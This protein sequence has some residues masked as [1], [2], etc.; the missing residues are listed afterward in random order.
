MSAIETINRPV[1][2]DGTEEQ[3]TANYATHSF[4]YYDD[5]AE[6]VDC[7]C[8]PWHTAASYPCGQEPDRETVVVNYN[9]PF[10]EEPWPDYNDAEREDH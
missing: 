6:C 8:K 1:Q 7:F 3:K 5:E 4:V 2:F 10:P 9:F